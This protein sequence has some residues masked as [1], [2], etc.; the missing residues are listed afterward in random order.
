MVQKHCLIWKWVAEGF[1]ERKAGSSSNSLFEQGEEYFHELINRSMIQAVESKESGIVY[2][3]RVHDMVLD[4]ICDISNEEDLVTVSSYDDG[5]GRGTPSSRS[6][7]RRLAHHNR[8][9]TKETTTHQDSP[10]EGA[11]KL[12]SLVA[13]GCDIDGWA[14]H[15]SSNKFCVC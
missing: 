3:C 5:D 4:L 14:L 9:I 10:T 7:V 11:N 6:V 2:G 15:P 8:R 12:R 1:I 13:C